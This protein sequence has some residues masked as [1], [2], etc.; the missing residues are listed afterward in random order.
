MIFAGFDVGSLTAKAVIFEDGK[1]A[2]KSIIE[3]KAAPQESGE[4][5]MR[6]ALE[7]A[8]IK[9]EDITYIVST[10]YG[11]DRIPIAGS[12]QPE[13][14]CHARGAWWRSPSTRTVIDIGGKDIRAIR[15]DNIGNVITYRYNDTCATGTGR[16]LEVMTKVLEAESNEMGMTLKESIKNLNL[17]NQL[18]GFYETEIFTL[19]NG[20]KTVFDIIHRLS[21]SVSLHVA[22]LARSIG[23]EDEVVITGGVAKNRSVSSALKQNLPSKLTTLNGFDPQLT[24]ALGA[25]LYAQEKFSEM[26]NAS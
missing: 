4:E 20:G 25:A 11:K 19:I 24:G 9:M 22:A 1:I 6:L 18:A 2:G 13:I 12:S 7:D 14:A 15:V 10:G 17:S 5:V 23:I 3:T 26:K 8:C 16:V 21:W